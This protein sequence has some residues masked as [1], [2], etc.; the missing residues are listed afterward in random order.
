MTN[1][2]QVMELL[3]GQSSDQ[4]LWSHPLYQGSANFFCMWT[5]GQMVNISGF[6]D[7]IGLYCIVFLFCLYN[8][9]KM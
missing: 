1:I 9:L 4:M 6:V 2:P 5:D 8:P 3:S 7:H